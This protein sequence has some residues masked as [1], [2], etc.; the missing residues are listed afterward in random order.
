MRRTMMTRTLL[1]FAWNRRDAGEIGTTLTMPFI[2]PKSILRAVVLAVGTISETGLVPNLT[3]FNLARRLARG[4]TKKF[5]TSRF[6]LILK[7]SWCA[8]LLYGPRRKSTVRTECNTTFHI[9]SM[10]A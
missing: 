10:V 9:E 2:N 8:E 1:S 7:L 5:V 3:F 4:V 6:C